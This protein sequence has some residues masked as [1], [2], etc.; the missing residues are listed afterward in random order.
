MVKLGSLQFL[1]TMGSFAIPVFLIT[2]WPGLF[3][4]GRLSAAEAAW[5]I[6]VPVLLFFIAHVLWKFGIRRYTSANG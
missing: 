2:N 5:G 1:Q 4:L 6:A 3:A